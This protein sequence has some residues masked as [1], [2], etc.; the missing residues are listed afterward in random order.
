MSRARSGGILQDN[1]PL[2]LKWTGD[3]PRRGE[4]GLQIQPA[5]PVRA[6]L[7]FRIPGWSQLNVV[8]V[9]GKPVARPQSGRYLELD[10]TWK[11]GDRL[12]FEFRPFLRTV[13]GDREAR[14]RASFYFGPLLLAYDQAYNSFDAD[15]L[16]VADAHDPA[17]LTAVNP[18][19]GT[20]VSW[21]LFDLRLSGKTVRLCDFAGA[22][23]NGTQYRT[24]LPMTG[25]P[26]PAVT[27][28]PPDAGRIPPG[29][30]RFRWSGPAHSGN[31]VSAYRLVIAAEP[32]FATAVIDMPDLKTNQTVIG[33][34]LMS[35]LTPIT[36]YWWRV[37]AQRGSATS[38]PVGPPAYFSVDPKLPPT[39]P[40][41]LSASPRVLLGRNFP[42]RT[43]AEVSEPTAGLG[44]RQ[45][46]GP[47]GSAFTATEMDGSSGRLSYS[48]PEF[49]DEDWSLAVRFRVETLPVGRLGQVFSAWTAPQDD[50]LRLVIDGGKLYSRIEAGA[51]F[52]TEGV[53]ITTRRWYLAVVVKEGNRL[54]LFLNGRE[55]GT[56]T[57]PFSVRSNSR[58]V[59][60]GGNPRFAGNEFLHTRLA[61]FRLVNAALAP[62]AA[63][64]G[65]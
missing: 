6:R 34:D 58:E 50:P 64:A 59:A 1:T 51:A 49:P 12:A 17:R 43:P 32:S 23:A 42:G 65:L 54:T 13:H 5:R 48:V 24:W 7:R 56:A 27:R 25:A 40:E 18:P 14:G 8:S 53:A 47:D 63:A 33:A 2:R 26:P 30:A 29:A 39:P 62:D 15:Q 9:N 22:G 35:R 19:S 46:P 10:R 41:T 16:P 20:S 3:Y 60:F 44:V 37:D 36:R 11:P 45:A 61:G 57:V 28:A 31:E 21:V 4:V 55:V 52:S 38:L